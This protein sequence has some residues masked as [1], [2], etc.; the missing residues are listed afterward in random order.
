MSAF[1]AIVAIASLLA[2]GFFANSKAQLTNS[3]SVELVIFLALCGIGCW[4]LYLFR[5]TG[6]AS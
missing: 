3:G 6:G 5:T 2:A 4:A 1:L